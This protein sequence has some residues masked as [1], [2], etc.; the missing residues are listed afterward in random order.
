MF[1]DSIQ[2]DNEEVDG[3]ATTTMSSLMIDLA[4]VL[5]DNTVFVFADVLSV[6]L[7][8]SI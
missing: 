5:G 4:L 2:E 6:L 7:T 3:L 1:F 8:I